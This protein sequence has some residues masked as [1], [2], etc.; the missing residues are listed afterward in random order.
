MLSISA[1]I[2]GNLGY[3][4]LSLCHSL[5]RSV[6]LLCIFEGSLQRLKSSLFEAQISSRRAGQALR[7]D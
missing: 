4:H 2:T 7:R 1:P 5:V 3:Y 6:I